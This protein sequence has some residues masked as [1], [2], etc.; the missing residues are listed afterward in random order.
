MARVLFGNVLADALKAARGAQVFQVGDPAQ[1]AR[2]IVT[3]LH[4]ILQR[5]E[6]LVEPV[7]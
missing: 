7:H 3:E 1:S 5:G 2:I 6:P 4:R